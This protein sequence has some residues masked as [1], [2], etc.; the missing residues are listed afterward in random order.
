MVQDHGLVKTLTMV[1]IEKIIPKHGKPVDIEPVPVGDA[2]IFRLD[3]TRYYNASRKIT[4][5]TINFVY[6][7]LEI[8]KVLTDY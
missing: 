5:A 2:D 1:L 4:N 6:K 3:F 7:D 8:S